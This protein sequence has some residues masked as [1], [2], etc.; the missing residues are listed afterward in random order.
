MGGVRPK[1]HHN[2]DFSYT[3]SILPSLVSVGRYSSIALG[4]R[5]MGEKHPL[6]W[7][8]TSPVF[9]NR[10]LMMETFESDQGSVGTYHRHQY[11]PAPITIGGS[12]DLGV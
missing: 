10:R 9:Y 6:E 7:A 11:R 4:L 8:S 3:H 1:S 5:V 2:G 12:S